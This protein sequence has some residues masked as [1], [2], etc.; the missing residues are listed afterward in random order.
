M[1]SA[2][3]YL[4]RHQSVIFREFNNKK[5]LSPKR[6]LGAGPPSLLSFK[7]KIKGRKML[8]F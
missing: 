3:S 5:F 2:Y 7:L 4:F 6:T 1:L 8:N